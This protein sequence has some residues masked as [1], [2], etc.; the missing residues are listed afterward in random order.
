MP[1]YVLQQFA[2]T[3][4]DLP[5]KRA[6]RNAQLAPACPSLCRE[7]MFCV[8]HAIKFFFWSV[9]TYDCTDAEGE[10]FEKLP[11]AIRELMGDV[12]VQLPCR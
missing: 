8:E 1:G 3:E 7:P 4:A 11:E 10:S 12:D 5:R 6:R 2:W 9:L